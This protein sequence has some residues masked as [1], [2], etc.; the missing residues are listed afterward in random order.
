[1][2]G[3]CRVPP[4]L[5]SI[6]SG[7]LLIRIYV[8]RC[9]Y[10]FDRLAMGDIRRLQTFS[11]MALPFNLDLAHYILALG[12]KPRADFAGKAVSAATA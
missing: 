9:P 3:Y 4:L 10:R 5:C 11:P 2:A 7:D 8:T 12:R 6:E 1:M